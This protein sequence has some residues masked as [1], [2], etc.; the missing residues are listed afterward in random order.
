MII[1]GAVFVIS[2]QIGTPFQK[3]DQKETPHMVFFFVLV[4]LLIPG[5]HVLSFTTLVDGEHQNSILL[6]IF[7]YSMG[8]QGWNTCLPAYLM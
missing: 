4:V 6:P 2:S 1:A 5:F 8:E 3:L 7:K